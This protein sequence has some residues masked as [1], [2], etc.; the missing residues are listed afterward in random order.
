MTLE[1]QVLYKFTDWEIY[2]SIKLKCLINIFQLK[3]A[4]PMFCKSSATVPES[5]QSK[6][7]T[8]FAEAHDILLKS[9][10]STDIF[11]VAGVYWFQSDVCL[12]T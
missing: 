5:Y 6:L 3:I 1:I 8:I 10:L 9:N 11:V 7:L 2:L 4:I 12:K